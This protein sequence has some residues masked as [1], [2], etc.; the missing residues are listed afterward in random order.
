ML[1]RSMTNDVL[2]SRLDT[3]DDPA[4]SMPFERLT[5][6]VEI[7]EILTLFGVSAVP[8]P[9]WRRIFVPIFSSPVFP[10]SAPYQVFSMSL[11]HQYM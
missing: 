8:C 3:H 2:S 1:S 4:P 11:E 9:N 10:P 7:Q 5:L 6:G